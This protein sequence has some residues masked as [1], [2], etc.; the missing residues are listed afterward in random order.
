[1]TIRLILIHSINA[2]SGLDWS[3]RSR[4][5]R[6]IERFVKDPYKE[7]DKEWMSWLEKENGT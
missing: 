7:E 2:S 6:F 5:R 1:M 3:F 4:I